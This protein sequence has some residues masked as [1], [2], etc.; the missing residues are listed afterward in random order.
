MDT[1]EV[2]ARLRGLENGPWKKRARFA[3]R[4]LA[5]RGPLDVASA[6]A[7]D[8]FSIGE[9]FAFGTLTEMNDSLR[10]RG[11]LPITDV[12]VVRLRGSLDSAFTYLQLME[13]AIETGYVPLD[14]IRTDARASLAAVLW[15]TPARSFLKAYEYMPVEHLANRIGVEGLSN[16]APPEIDPTA[17]IRF[18]GFLTSL[19]QIES[20]TEVRAWQNVL[21]NQL[22]DSIDQDDYF[23][24][25]KRVRTTAP[26]SAPQVARGAREHV[27]RLADF[28]RAVPSDLALRFG[29]FYR[30]WL[31]KLFANYGYQVTEDNELELGRL[32]KEVV[33]SGHCK[34]RFREAGL[35][36]DRGKYRRAPHRLD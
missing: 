29:I 8:L 30:Y 16:K 19:R 13:L 34:E 1:D 36:P 15:A 17:S 6:G 24:Y 5:P 35:Q 2:A 3:E 27:I 11:T 31:E 26:I 22:P 21:E 25:L 28:F 12:S 18:A 10:F 4:R 33:R 32:A 9:E 20:N 7:I 23:S 14:S